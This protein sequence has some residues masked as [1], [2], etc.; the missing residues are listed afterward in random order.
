[1]STTMLQSLSVTPAA[2]SPPKRRRRIKFGSFPQAPV[3]YRDG[4]VTVLRNNN[5]IRYNIWYR[6]YNPL[7]LQRQNT[8]C[9]KAPI[10][11]VHG[12]P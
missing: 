11:V 7:A 4:R 1:M 6:V 12:G 9:H 2:M 5:E 8:A 10:V 3:N